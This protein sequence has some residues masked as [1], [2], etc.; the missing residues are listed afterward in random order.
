MHLEVDEL[1]RMLSSL[2]IYA[3]A[4]LAIDRSAAARHACRF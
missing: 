2:C 3:N 4:F 1:D